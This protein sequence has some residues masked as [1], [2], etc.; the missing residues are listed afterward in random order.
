MINVELIHQNDDG[1][2]SS[3]NLKI[4]LDNIEFISVKKKI[5]D[6]KGKVY[7]LK[8][9]NMPNYQI[10]NFGI[11]HN[12]GGKRKGSIA[13]YLEPWHA[14]IFDFLDLKKQT[15]KEEVR[16]RDLF[17]AMWMNDLFMERIEA[18]EEW[19]LMCPDECPGLQDVYGE[20]FKKLYLKYEKEGRQ[21]RK[22]PARE[23]WNKILESQVETG[24]P[25]L[26]YKD[27][28]N[29]KSNQQNLGTIKTSNLCLTGDTLLDIKIGGEICKKTL[30]EVINIF[31]SHEEIEVLSYSIGSDKVDF[32]KIVNAALTNDNATLLKITH[33]ETNKFIECTEDHEIFT[34]NRG[35]VK[36]KDLLENDDLYIN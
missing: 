25:Y 4:D 15:G 12:G 23:V 22:V 16:A 1:E 17:L 18:N 10:S 31:E 3:E 2:L 28:C 32:K 11:A 35:Y 30:Q 20:D 19:S 27:A 8:I 9:K 26:L 5:L 24:V 34:L 6:H 21:K 13:V 36:A 7:D 14:D 29:E 33:V